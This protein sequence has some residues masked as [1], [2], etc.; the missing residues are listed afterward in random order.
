MKA[1]PGILLAIVSTMTA[2]PALAEQEAKAPPAIQ[3]E[4]DGFIK[5]F[6]AAVKAGDAEAIAGLT[7]LPFMN[8]D[9]IATPAQFREK[10]YAR[11][12]DKKTRACLRREKAIYERDGENKDAFFVFC[13][14]S[15]YVFNR[16]PAG[17]RFTDIGAND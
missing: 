16:T 7:K 9:G 5:G 15:I 4:F 2:V 10:I 8:D 1:L 6:R 17:F 12:F 11:S 3:K 14:E 13:G